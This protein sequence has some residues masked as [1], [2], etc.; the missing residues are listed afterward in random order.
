MLG[1]RNRRHGRYGR[2]RRHGG[3]LRGYG[4]PGTRQFEP[5][6]AFAA[7]AVTAPA[8]SGAQPGR[9]HRGLREFRGARGGLG[10]AAVGAAPPGRQRQRATA[11]TGPG[12]QLPV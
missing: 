6:G 8:A 5:A 2:Q 10:G 12:G 11:L 3:A 1:H 4:A 9:V 7:V